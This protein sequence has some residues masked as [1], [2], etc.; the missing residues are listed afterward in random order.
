MPFTEFG[1]IIYDQAYNTSFH[2]NWK[3]FGATLYYQ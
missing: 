2:Q 3:L 1:D